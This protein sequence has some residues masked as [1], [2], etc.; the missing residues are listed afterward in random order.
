[1]ALNLVE[2]QSLGP[3]RV[4]ARFNIPPDPVSA[5]N[6]DNW[7][8]KFHILLTCEWVIIPRYE[9]MMDPS[10]PKSVIIDTGVQPA[11]NILVQVNN[12]TGANG[13]PLENNTVSFRGTHPLLIWR[14]GGS[15]GE[16]LRVKRLIPDVAGVKLQLPDGTTF[17]FAQGQADPDWF[18]LNTS[19]VLPHLSELPPGGQ[20]ITW[21][22]WNIIPIP[23]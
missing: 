5:T 20:Q 22:I 3:T 9:M 12:I 6:P 7:D 1:M 23:L 15:V 18:E 10:D 16:W 14:D 17:D 8:F 2:A 11:E 4:R 21:Q 19:V 13:E